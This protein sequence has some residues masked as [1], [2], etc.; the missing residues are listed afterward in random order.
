M[1]TKQRSIRLSFQE[2]L[3]PLKSTGNGFSENIYSLLN[4]KFVLTFIWRATRYNSRSNHRHSSAFLTH[5]LNNI[6]LEQNM[7]GSSQPL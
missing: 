6:V 1:K 3:T 4:A 7:F 2:G 5:I